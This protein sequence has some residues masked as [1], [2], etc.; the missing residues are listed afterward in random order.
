MSTSSM[1]PTNSQAAHQ[2]VHINTDKGEIVIELL[3]EEGP[4]AAANFVS[5]VN[6]KFYDGLTFHRVEPGLIIQGGDPNGNG[7]GG[8][9]YEFEDDPVR[10]PYSKGIVAMANRGPNTNG[11]QFFIMLEDTN[12]FAPKYSIFGRVVSGQDVAAKIQVGDKMNT[13][14]LE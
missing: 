2:R 10:L 13:V 4:K 14:T 5:L 11:S 6:R 1:T 7:T 12:L 3:P 9:G 8:P